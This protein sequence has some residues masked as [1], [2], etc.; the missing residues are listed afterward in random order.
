MPAA[1]PLIVSSEL[2]IQG[3]SKPPIIAVNTPAVA[4]KPL[5]SEIARHNGNAIRNTRK[6]AVRSA[7]HF[8]APVSG[9]SCGAGVAE[10]CVTA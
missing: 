7:C 3:A 2:L 5:A 9:A 6:P 8:A 4:G 1:G 10:L